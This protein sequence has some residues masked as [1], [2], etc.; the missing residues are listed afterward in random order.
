MV[1]EQCASRWGIATGQVC[2]RTSGASACS[3]VTPLREAWRC[4]LVP[5]SLCTIPRFLCMRSIQSI[6]N[7][8]FQEDTFT[9][10]NLIST[11]LL[12]GVRANFFPTPEIDLQTHSCCSEPF[13]MFLHRSV[14][15]Q[16]HVRIHAQQFFQILATHVML[17]LLQLLL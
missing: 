3:S 13:R 11:W 2:P 17:S 9:I 7:V 10:W 15:L 1:S 8:S 16:N 14:W 6:L 4:Y 12:H 5:R